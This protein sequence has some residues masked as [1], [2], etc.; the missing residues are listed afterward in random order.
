MN[1]DSA[2]S[3]LKVLEEKNHLPTEGS[4]CTTFR[5]IATAAGDR[6]TFAAS[7]ARASI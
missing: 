2:F 5:S 6:D 1:G 7:T 3:K 4:H